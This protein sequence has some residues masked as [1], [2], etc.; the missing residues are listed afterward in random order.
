MKTGSDEAAGRLLDVPVRMAHRGG[1]QSL[2]AWLGQRGDNPINAGRI[3]KQLVDRLAP[4]AA[5]LK[6]P[7]C[8]VQP[9]AQ[10][11][12]PGSR[13]RPEHSPAYRKPHTRW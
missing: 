6:H 3:A 11:G 4:N 7:A 10:R 2:I 12:Q 1:N 8:P 9:D 5:P 13:H